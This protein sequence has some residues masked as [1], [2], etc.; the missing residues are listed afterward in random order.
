MEVNAKYSPKDF[1]ELK[2]YQVNQSELLSDDLESFITM[3]R[4]RVS[5]KSLTL[6]IIIEGGDE[7]HGLG[8]NEEN[9]KV[10]GKY[11]ELG[12]IEKFEIKY[13]EGHSLY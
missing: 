7:N 11:K 3:W 8:V 4:D 5:K 9:M 6:I 13:T 2:I 12:I 10:I 1:Y